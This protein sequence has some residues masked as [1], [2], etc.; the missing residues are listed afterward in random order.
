MSIKN[1]TSVLSGFSKKLFG[2]VNPVKKIE[3]KSNE[4]YITYLNREINS[5]EVVKSFDMTPLPNVQVENKIYYYLRPIIYS[6]I[7]DINKS[8]KNNS[9]NYREVFEDNDNLINEV[10]SNCKI[11]ICGGDAYE[12]YI[13]S[14]EKQIFQT[15]DADLRIIPEKNALKYLRGLNGDNIKER[16]KNIIFNIKHAVMYII[17]NKLNSYFN[18]NIEYLYKLQS[19]CKVEF[20]RNIDDKIFYQDDENILPNLSFLSACK[21]TYIFEDLRYINSLIDL[22]PYTYIGVPHFRNINEGNIYNNLEN[23][24]GHIYENRI[25]DI[26]DTRI[27]DKYNGFF[28]FLI[29][30]EEDTIKEIETNLYILSLGYLIWDI[31]RMIMWSLITINTRIIGRFADSPYYNM[32][33]DRYLK[34]YFQLIEA[35]NNPTRYINCES[36]KKFIDKCKG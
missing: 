13:N 14:N 11:V 18:D 27:Q 28:S 24:K 29:S 26:N 34:K 3:K 4:D 15:H 7:K 8:L 21:Y 20:Q 17:V 16:T 35:L 23:F 36:M 12:Y 30:E 1:I 9:F 32:K 6:Y 10:V 25:T 33:L 5:L 19:N 2:K 31:V 22:V